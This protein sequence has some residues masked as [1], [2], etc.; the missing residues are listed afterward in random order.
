MNLFNCSCDNSCVIV[1]SFNFFLMIK[2]VLH[3]PCEN[4]NK[5]NSSWCY[6]T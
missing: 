5:D 2:N 1:S 4:K 3:Y 6:L